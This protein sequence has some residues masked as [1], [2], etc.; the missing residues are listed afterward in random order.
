MDE[1]LRLVAE[2]L[3][4]EKMAAVAASHRGEVPIGGDPQPEDEGIALVEELPAKEA[5]DAPWSRVAALLAL[6][7]LCSS[8]VSNALKLRLHPG[9]T[10]WARELRARDGT[11]CR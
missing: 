3:D 2:L 7:R 6:N 4:G 8:L 1:R 9:T 10:P 11:R 5:A